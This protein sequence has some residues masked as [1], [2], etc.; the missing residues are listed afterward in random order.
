MKIRLTLFIALFFAASAFAGDTPF[1]NFHCTLGSPMERQEFDLAF[2][3]SL[4]DVVE[5]QSLLGRTKMQFERVS[6]D[7]V[8]VIINTGLPVL[9]QATPH[10][11]R[12]TAPLT[13]PQFDFSMGVNA[14][15]MAEGDMF[16][17][18]CLKQ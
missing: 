9:A 13:T 4:P 10:Q 18:V 16:T 5:W 8:S 12:F 6:T 3:H 14:V 11:F 1:W 15:G 17:L 2:Q 7:T